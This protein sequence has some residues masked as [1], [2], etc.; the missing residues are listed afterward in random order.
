M[1]NEIEGI[2]ENLLTKKSPWAR[3]IK[4]RILHHPQEELTLTLPKLFH[5]IEKN[6][7][8]SYFFYK[9]RT[10]FTQKPDNDPMQKEHYKPVFLMNI[11]PKIFQNKITKT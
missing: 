10:T 9:P 4:C 8:F 11:D 2:I 7:T 1:S 3:W 5:E 6:K